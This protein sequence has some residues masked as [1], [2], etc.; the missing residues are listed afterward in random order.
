MP[1]EAQMRGR[2]KE[3]E[4]L[5]FT[6]HEEPVSSLEVSLVKLISGARKRVFCCSFLLGGKQIQ[7]ALLEAADRLRGHVYVITS[8]DEK[9][10]LKGFAEELEGVPPSV[11]LDRSRKN[12]DVLTKKGVYL[13]GADEVHA[14]FCVVDDG[15][16]VVSSANFD[17]N[18][19]GE[20]RAQASGEIG[21]CVDGDRAAALA[22]LFRHLWTNACAYDSPPDEGG[23]VWR[24]HG[25]HPEAPLK[26]PK[27]KVGSVLWTGFGSTAILQEIQDAAR[28]AK[29]RLRLA[30]YSFTRMARR[31]ELLLDLLLERAAAG[32]QIELYMRDRSV[33]LKDLARLSVPGVTVRADRYNHAKYMLADSS[34][35][36]L[37]SA[38]FDGQHGLDSGVETGVRLKAHELEELE[39][40]HEW[41]WSEASVELR[42]PGAPEDLAGVNTSPWPFGREFVVHGDAAGARL[43]EELV[44]GPALA[45][46]DEAVPD[47]V[48]ILGDGRSARLRRAGEIWKADPISNDRNGPSIA[49]LLAAGAPRASI[50]LPEGVT[51]TSQPDGPRTR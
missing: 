20:N 23:F 8:L 26:A 1:R 50:W 15:R 9:S 44:R 11:V 16:A 10:L 30:S 4:S 46:H 7:E 3:L 12:F 6:R 24:S 38:N 21:L 29:S 51:V 31:P 14:K 2:W 19:L 40:Y 18:G 5:L 25:V 42:R 48:T 43:A 27:A 45:V 41:A 34:S 49:R 36:A 28:S 17:P 13:R 32:V 39:R 33:D 37:F 22:G 47:L 35:G